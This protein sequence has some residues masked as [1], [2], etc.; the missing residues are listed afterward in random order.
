MN[1]ILI[2]LI[3]VLVLVA[4]YYVYLYFTSFPYLVS[5]TYDLKM[6]KPSVP[7]TALTNL[8]SIRYTFSTWIY[9]T[10]LNNHGAAAPTGVTGSGSTENTL[11]SLETGVGGS[12]N[13]GA[14]NEEYF[15]LYFQK[16][17]P[18]LYLHIRGYQSNAD[19]KQSTS[20]HTAISEIVVSD[21]FPL[22]SWTSVIVSVDTYFIDIYMNGNLVKSVAINSSSQLPISQID[23]NAVINFGKGQDIKITRL[24]R[25]PYQTDP[26]T[27]YTIFAQ[28]SGQQNSS[29]THFN[30]WYTGSADASA[31]PSAPPQTNLIQV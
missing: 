31:N 26:G 12:H 10:N 24:M 11:F 20:G 21:N 1:L 29:I 4:L 2:A 23:S 30:V 25:L 18:K 15:S 13:I 3:L 9:V 5:S 7:S 17:S 22:Q 8:T 19:Y 27:A 28:G 16:D 6:Q 14:T